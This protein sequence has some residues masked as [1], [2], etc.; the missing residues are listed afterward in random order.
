MHFRVMRLLESNP[1]LSQ[2]E[3][4][5][6]LGASLGRVNYCLQALADKG[7]IKIRNFQASN[8]KLRYAYVLTPRGIAE[9]ARLTRGFLERKW[10]EYEAL[11]AEIAALEEELSLGA[12]GAPA[13][14][15]S[16]EA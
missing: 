1:H 12:E 11:Q 7:Y 3:I 14:R 13:P 10:A 8:H 9:K 15:T 4:A 16:G 5:R 6:E 2:R